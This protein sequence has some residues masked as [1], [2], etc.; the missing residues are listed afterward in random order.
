M[1]R[2]ESYYIKEQIAGQLVWQQG[3]DQ[4]VTSRLV[5]IPMCSPKSAVVQLISL[6]SSFFSTPSQKPVP[7]LRLSGEDQV[8]S[9]LSPSHQFGRGTSSPLA[10]LLSSSDSK[11]LSHTF[12][13][14]DTLHN[15]DGSDRSAKLH[16][17]SVGALD[18]D[19]GW[20]E[21]KLEPTQLSAN[22]SHVFIPFSSSVRGLQELGLGRNQS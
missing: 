8:P 22:K 20:G 12:P 17:T 2:A 3:G 14:E 1:E 7:R 9:V 4:D 16:A 6:S 15:L 10:S 21:T 11:D 18:I 19:A 5:R 13:S